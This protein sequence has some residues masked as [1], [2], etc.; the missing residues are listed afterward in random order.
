MTW[1]S[2]HRKQ[3]AARHTELTCINIVKCRSTVTSR[4]CAVST[5]AMEDSLFF[6]DHPSELVPEENF[7][8][9]W[10]KGR[11][12]EADIPT[13][14]LGATPS[15]L[16]S[17]HLWRKPKPTVTRST[18]QCIPL[19][20]VSYQCRDIGICTRI[21]ICIRDPDRRRNLIVCS[22]SHCQ[23]SLKISC[24]SVWKFL[25]KVANRQTDRQTNNNENITSLAEVTK[26]NRIHVG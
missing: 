6:R 25:R 3:N 21:H 14:R 26:R 7:W 16:T 10:Y 20:G 11:F 19:Q 12:T 18:G 13:I 17:A 2:W 24:K 1:R 23:P 4:S 9:L 22:L 15:V 8:T 5:V